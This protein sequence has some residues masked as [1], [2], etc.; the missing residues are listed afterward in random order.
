[1]PEKAVFIAPG[2]AGQIPQGSEKKEFLNFGKN[3]LDFPG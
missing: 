3:L 1:M 2:R